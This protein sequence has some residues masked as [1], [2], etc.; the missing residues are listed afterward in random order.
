MGLLIPSDRPVLRQD[1]GL[2]RELDVL[3]RLQASLPDAYEIY[4]SVAWHC[5]HR[6]DDRHGEI[7][8]VIMAPTGNLLLMEI[9]AGNVI[10]R[11]G[12]MFKVYSSGERDVARQCQVQYS[13]MVNRL[14]EAG[15]HPHVTNCLVLP[16]FS[17]DGSHV[18]SFPRDRI[19]DATDY[20]LLGT[21]IKE[22]LAV[23][24]G[25]S[26]LEAIRHFLK[27]EFRVSTN[28]AVLRDQLQSTTQQ[29][30]DGL[31]TW[32]P[33][34]AVPTGA[35]RI[36]ATAGSGK[37]QLAIRLLEDAAAQSQTS[38]Y[39]CFNRSLADH[40]GK[41]APTRAHISSFH[42][43]C[44]DHYRRQHQ[45]PDFADPSVFKT[46]ASFYLADSESFVPRYD[47]L[48]VDEGQDFDPAWMGSLLPQ[49]KE[50]GR[51]Y[52]M[53]DDDQRL[54]DREPFDL[55][56]TV[57][58]TCRDNHRSPK[59]V[60]QTINALSLTGSSITS[61][62][63][64]SGEVPGFH[65]YESDDLLTKITADAV[66]SLLARGFGI[67]DIVV[68]TGRGRRKSTLLNSETIGAHR[69]R[70]FTGTYS[71]NAE[72]E[73]TEGDLLVESVYRFKGQSAPA[74]VL[75]EVDFVELSSLER[76]KLFVGMTR[77]QMAVEV[78]M[79]RAAEAILSGL[80]S[81]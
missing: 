33:R 59:A 20:D 12:S 9:K 43:L 55:T 70:R 67:H 36:Q 34:I 32:V 21:K 46:V 31:A 79:S 26:D 17:I 19:V 5:I 42:E 53:E 68:L 40:M 35:M 51:L 49:L 15:I 74:I 66:V 16:D 56:D 77:A 65:V 72:P 57:T 78:V 39:V 24:Q 10:L 37:T 13:A 22:F 61:R 76:R 23:G 30:A 54:Y 18:I 73:W 41:I 62:S 64:F 25:N 44:V 81:G 50:D 11:S 28:L 6:G 48:I 14:G 80:I 63:P 3:K 45:E 8:V 2:Y 27:N 4:H 29:L 69:T 75:S 47:L 58:V 7:D 71:R 1:A 60:C 38:L 52:V